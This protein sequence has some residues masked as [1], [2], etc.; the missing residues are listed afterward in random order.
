MF[1]A[2]QV[3]YLIAGNLRENLRESE[4]FAIIVKNP[5]LKEIHVK[6]AAF[7]M[8]TR[9]IGFLLLT[10]LQVSV[11]TFGDSNSCPHLVV[12]ASMEE[13]E[14]C[15]YTA[16]K[17]SVFNLTIEKGNGGEVVCLVYISKNGKPKQHSL[18]AETKCRLFGDYNDT[19]SVLLV[20]LE[21]KHTGSYI[22]HVQTFFP[23]PFTAS[24]V[25]RTFLHVHD[26]GLVPP[27]CHIVSFVVTWIMI[28]V[29]VFL[30]ACLMVAVFI[31]CKRK[32]CRECDSR[33]KEQN[34][35]NHSASY[36]PMEFIDNILEKLSE[37]ESM[38]TVVNSKAS[39]SNRYIQIIRQKT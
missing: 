4:A 16:P 18:T 19:Y 23:P 34:G 35:K 1:H 3:F 11:Q 15:Q 5:R 10:S 30:F 9:L 38:H 13:V 7:V 27:D 24:V 36:L 33:K 29:S 12:A 22:C 2:D 31:V 6:K 32:Q 37:D 8:N 21:A 25:N 20:K 14:L 17:P 26:F 39:T 28:G